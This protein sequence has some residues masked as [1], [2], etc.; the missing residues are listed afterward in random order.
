MERSNLYVSKSNKKDFISMAMPTVKIPLSASCA[1]ASATAQRGRGVLTTRH[2]TGQ[3][4]SLLGEGREGF[5]HAPGNCKP[6]TQNCKLNK[7]IAADKSGPGWETRPLTSG[8]YRTGL[9]LSLLPTSFMLNCYCHSPLQL[10]PR[11]VPVSIPN[12]ENPST[13][14]S[15][16]KHEKLTVN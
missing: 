3:P 16:P 9:S 4:D 7:G 1:I 15:Y 8:S 13:L 11:P 10:S 2:E 14:H 12:A 5:H 6:P